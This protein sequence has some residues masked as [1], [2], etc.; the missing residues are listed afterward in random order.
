MKRKALLT[1]AKLQPFEGP[2]VTL[3]P[4]KEWEFEGVTP[5]VEVERDGDKARAVVGLTNSS[6]VNVF[7]RISVIAVEV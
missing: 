2:W 5:A 4:D 6:E 7:A 3:D 1:G